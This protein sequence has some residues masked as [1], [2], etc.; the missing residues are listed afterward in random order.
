MTSEK[1]QLFL[2]VCCFCR[3]GCTSAG[4]PQ[5]HPPHPGR[6]TGERVEDAWQAQHHRLC[7]QSETGVHRP[8]RRG[9]RL[10]RNGPQW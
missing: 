10:L 8:L 6:Q 5:R 3:R 2:L 9:T 1:S 7:G 4:V